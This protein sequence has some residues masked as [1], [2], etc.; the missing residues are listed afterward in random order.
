VARSRG[1][2]RVQYRLQISTYGN[3]S[4]ST[5]ITIGPSI[6]GLRGTQL[7]GSINYTLVSGRTQVSSGR[8]N[9]EGS[10]FTIA[11]TLAETRI[12]RSYKPLYSVRFPALKQINFELS[13]VPYRG[14]V[15]ARVKCFGGYLVITN[16]I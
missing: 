8:I 2:G 5:I 16:V 15:V 6:T 13:P 14:N 10:R 12:P 9:P 11:H 1:S 4:Y 7:M 3:N